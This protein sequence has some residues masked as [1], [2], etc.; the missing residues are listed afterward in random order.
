MKRKEHR[1]TILHDHSYSDRHA[2]AAERVAGKTVVFPNPHSPAR[3]TEAEADAKGDLAKAWA[4]I[5]PDGARG[6]PATLLKTILTL[7]F[8]WALISAF[9]ALEP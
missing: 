3:R 1:A 8:A 2:V 9:L 4:I 6:L 5:A 7:V